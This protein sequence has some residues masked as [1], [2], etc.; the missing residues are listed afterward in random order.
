MKVEPSDSIKSVTGLL[1]LLS[2]SGDNSPT[3]PHSSGQACTADPTNA[4]LIDGNS[5]V[6]LPKGKSCL[7]RSQG[8]VGCDRFP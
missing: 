1:V 4:I 3:C 2:D 6:S 7:Q 8:D 5:R